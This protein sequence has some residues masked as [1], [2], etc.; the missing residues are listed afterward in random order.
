MELSLDP[1]LLSGFL[2]AVIRVAAFVV[3]SPLLSPLLPW[4]AK[5]AVSVAIGLALA[6]PLATTPGLGELLGW[7]LVNAVLGGILGYLSGIL[8]YLFSIAGGLLDVQGGLMAGRVIDPAF[9]AESTAFNRLFSNGAVALFIAG[10]GYF[11]LV[12]GLA[13][14]VEVVALDGGL[15]LATEALTTQAIELSA[16][17]FLL[18]FELALPVSAA[19]FLT[20][21]T[22]GLASRFAPQMNVFLVGLPLKNLIVILAGSGAVLA[23][24][25]AGPD[26]I[27]ATEEVMVDLLRAIAPGE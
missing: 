9:G 14:S 5:L 15:T 20:E 4:V 8:V 24:A 18:G 26:L 16:R 7:G 1:A 17:T 6:E 19:L 11:V 27:R 22:L 21:I 23:F 25:G 12:R 10:G 13:T 3:V 2:L